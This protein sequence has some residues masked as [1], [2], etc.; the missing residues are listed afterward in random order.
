MDPNLIPDILAVTFFLASAI[1]APRA[2]MLYARVRNPRLFTLGLS[3]TLVALTAADNLVMN[4]F[5]IPYNTYWFLYIG[6]TVSF[7]FILLS[8]VKSSDEYLKQL[9][10]WHIFASMVMIGVLLCSPLLPAFPNNTVRAIASGSRSIPCFG[11]FYCY[12]TAFM[13]KNTRFSFLM[14]GA[15]LLLSLGPWIII[16]KY[17]VSNPDPLDMTGDIIRVIGLIIL[18]VAVLGG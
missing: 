3:M 13:K 15:F 4:F 10:Y 7:T 8:F 5:T 18:L 14:S 11:I 17:F 1:V 9:M 16:E 12:I 2:F 6:Q